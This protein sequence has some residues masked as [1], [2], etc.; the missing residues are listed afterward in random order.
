MKTISKVLLVLSF[1]FL[2]V[3]SS[4]AAEENNFEKIQKIYPNATE[5]LTDENLAESET[6]E[7]EELS[8]KVEKDMAENPDKVMYATP[9]DDNLIQPMVAFPYS[10]TFRFQSASLQGSSFT[11]MKYTFIKNSISNSSQVPVTFSLYTS[12]GTFVGSRIYPAG[13]TS[14]SSINITRGKTYKFV[15][16]GTSGWWKEGRGTITESLYQ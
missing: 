15:L 8:K 6:K 14:T 1:A 16:S 9:V 2:F 10:Y 11:P 5:V 12:D 3:G 13:T 4:A 7:L